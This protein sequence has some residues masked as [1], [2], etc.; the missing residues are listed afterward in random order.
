[1]D[2]EQ[3]LKEEA[4]DRPTDDSEVDGRTEWLMKWCQLQFAHAVMKTK[5][6]ITGMVEGMFRVNFGL[7]EPPK[8][9]DFIRQVFYPRFMLR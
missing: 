5:G 8:Y 3:L 9:S 6:K 7:D 1:M 4:K 2:D